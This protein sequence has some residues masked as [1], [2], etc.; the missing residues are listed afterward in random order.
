MTAP[1]TRGSLTVVGTGIGIAGQVTIEARAHMEQADKLLFLV[2]DVA[3]GYWLTKLNSTAESLQSFYGEGK[4][5]L[6]TYTEMIE[7][8]LSCVR[9]GGRVCVAFY[10]HPGVFVHPAHEAV[11]IAREEGYDARMLPGIS[12]EDCLFADLGLDPGK[13]GCQSYE[14]TDF[15]VH[16]RRFDPNVPLI[17]WQIAVIGEIGYRTDQAFSRAG[18]EVLVDALLEDYSPDHE[19]VVYEAAQFPICE[20]VMKRVPL[21]KL[22]D[23]PVTGISTLYV[24]PAAKTPMDEGMLERLGLRAATSTK[25]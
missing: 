21:A 12:A 18:V 16:H 19:V 1:K 23:A 4:D 15:L 3:T 13:L 9:E 7:R 20:P 2:A 6:V 11:R 14:S 8:I 5:R 24:P 10:G 17:L 22:P 25:G